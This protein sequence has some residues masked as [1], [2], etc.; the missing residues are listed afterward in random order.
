MKRFLLKIDDFRLNQSLS[1][2]DRLMELC[3]E[4]AVP[5]SIGVIGAGLR[6]GRFRVQHALANHCERGTIEL[7][8]HSYNHQ[9]LTKVDDA[10]VRWEIAATNS[11]IERHLGRPPQGFGAP[12]NKCD[13]RVARIARELGLRFTFET[14]FADAQRLTPEFNVPFDGQPNLGEFVRRAEKKSAEQL[15]VVQVHPGRWLSRGFEQAELCLRWLRDQ[16]YEPTTAREALGLVDVPPVLGHIHG[17]HAQVSHRLAD[18]WANNADAYDAKLS[19]FSSYFLARFRANSLGIHQLLERLDAD[20]ACRQVVDVGCGLAQWGLPFLDF[21]RDARVWA[22]DTDSTLTRALGAAVQDGLIPGDLRVVN[23]DFT[24][25]RKVGDQSVDRIVCANALNYIPLRAFAEQAQRICKPNALVILLNQTAAFNRAGTV[26]AINSANAGMAKERCMAALRQTLVRRGFAGLMPSRTTF[27]ADEVEAVLFA[28][29]FQL[30]DDF[31][32]S[33]ERR[34]DGAPTFEGLVFSRHAWLKAEDLKAPA[35]LPYRKTLCRA[36]MADLDVELYGSAPPDD[37]E[38][39]ALHARSGLI[40]SALGGSE[41][42]REV[43]AL[44]QSKAYLATANLIE[45]SHTADTDLRLVAAV[46]ALLDADVP[47][48]VELARSLEHSALDRETWQMLSAMTQLL[49]GDLPGA[50]KT[51]SQRASETVA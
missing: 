14:D 7:W 50:G 43:G 46:A 49:R 32:P 15:L 40:Q 12:F 41:L 6:G 8:N 19:N 13:A 4:L 1:K 34:Y 9:D 22:Y 36:G 17:T 23:E 33:W 16:G 31:I 27:T 24:A 5:M 25:S 44:L 29:G 10:T 47:R 20:A 51:L 3:S 11:A 21:D 38:L 48:G 28:F 18:F 37:A 39:Q 26:D 42:E 2:F 30:T 45:R 35:T